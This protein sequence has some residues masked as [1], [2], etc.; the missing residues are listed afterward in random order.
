MTKLLDKKQ[1]VI[2][3]KLT[4]YGRFKLSTGTFKPYYYSFYDAG[5]IYDG[6]YGG[7]WNEQHNDINVRI[8]EDTQYLSTQALFDGLDLEPWH[9]WVEAGAGFLEDVERHVELGFFPGDVVDSGMSIGGEP[10]ADFFKIDAGIGDAHFDG[11]LQQNA[12]AWKI[13]TL[14]GE[15]SGSRFRNN[16]NANGGKVVLDI[17]QIDITL[18]YIKKVDEKRFTPDPDSVYEILGSSPAFVDNRV[19]RVVENNLLLYVEEVNTDLLVENFEIEVFLSGTDDNQL[20]RKYFEHRPS[21]VIGGYMTSPTPPVN[22]VATF[23]TSIVEYY[24][25]VFADSQI[26]S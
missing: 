18:N 16:D 15:I 3:F 12:P 17:P 19:I 24:F 21:H 8:K 26:N 10:S 6:A 11:P 4:P 22:S 2:D 7:I 23:S 14:E 25:D 1:R 9:G 20:E 13:V 5:I